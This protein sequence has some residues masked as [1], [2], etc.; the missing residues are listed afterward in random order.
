MTRQS[1]AHI[2]LVVRDYDEAIDFYVGTLGF[3]LVADDYQPAQDKRWVLVALALPIPPS[4][5]S[6]TAFAART[7]RPS[8]RGRHSRRRLRHCRT[9][10]ARSWR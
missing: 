1:L 6:R 8:S 5:R 10:N 3:T 7:R 4:V 2:T 9:S